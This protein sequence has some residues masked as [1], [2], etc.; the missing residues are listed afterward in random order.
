[1][2]T[3]ALP[4]GR[5]FP[6]AADLLAS[7]GLPTTSLASTGRR[8]VLEEGG[9]RYILAKPSDVPLYVSRGAADLGFAGGDVLQESS[10]PLVEILDTGR[11]RCRIVVAGPA[12]QAPRFSGHRSELMGLRVATK[13]PRIADAHFSRKGVQVDVICLNGSIE[14]APSLGLSDCILDIVQTGSTLRANGLQ[15]FE[16]VAEVSMRLVAGRRSATLRRAEIVRISDAIE[17]V[18]IRERPAV[19]I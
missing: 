4:T 6:E 15:E 5:S 7:A 13:Y 1:M 10:L 18:C 3:V 16:F 11:S 14:L 19:G 12:Q 9:F 17:E 8:L 2:L